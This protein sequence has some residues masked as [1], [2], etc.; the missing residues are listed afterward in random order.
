MSFNAYPYF[1][2]AWEPYGPNLVGKATWVRG[3]LARYG[4]AKPIVLAEVGLLHGEDSPGRATTTEA[5]Y[6]AAQSLTALLAD[7]GRNPVSGVEIALWFTM[8]DVADAQWGKSDYGLASVNGAAYPSYNA[9]KFWAQTLKNTRYLYNRSEP[10][11]DFRPPGEGTR[12][13]RPAHHN[14]CDAKM[15]YAFEKVTPEGPRE[16]HVMWIDSGLENVQRTSAVRTHSVP[17]SRLE[18]VVDAYGNPLV[19]SN[20]DQRSSFIVGQS[21]VYV[22]LRPE[23][24]A[25]LPP[26]G[27]DIVVIAPPI[28]PIVR[29]I[30]TPTVPIT[31]TPVVGTPTPGT[32]T[33]AGNGAIPP[34]VSEYVPAV[35]TPTLVIGGGIAGLHP[36]VVTITP[37]DPSQ[38]VPMPLGRWLVGSP[39]SIYFITGTDAVITTLN[40]LY[41]VTF[42]YQVLTT[43]GAPD[44][45][46][47]WLNP[48]TW[49]WERVDS[50]RSSPRAGGGS[51]VSATTNKTGTFAVMAERYGVALP[52]GPR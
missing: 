31:G 50:V 22:T 6:Y 37:A 49:R 8:T 30:I 19:V 9:V 17:T 48:T 1:R 51:T 7:R 34:R 5:G 21:P 18:S 2:W 35:I 11:W 14:L 4:V 29:P 16:I 40:G 39:I 24:S 36:A 20:S 28:A 3:M 15:H 13:C 52:F 33:G 26:P 32:G 25:A 44:V 27:R 43:I 41:H 23:A 10:T 12:K 47:Y 46:I 42:T 38:S 45:A